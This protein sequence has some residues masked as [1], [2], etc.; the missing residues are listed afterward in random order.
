MSAV[1]VAK[2]VKL[3]RRL[4]GVERRLP[5]WPDRTA[6]GVVHPDINP[7]ECVGRRRASRRTA[8]ALRM[9]VGTPMARAPSRRHSLTASFQRLDT[10]GAQ[11][12]PC[13]ATSKG[14]GRGSA[15]P[16]RAPR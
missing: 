1:D 7:A 13:A 4:M 10:S 12:K 5:E 15:D 6:A 14:M 16:A 3:D 2:E 9:S 8:A 11:D